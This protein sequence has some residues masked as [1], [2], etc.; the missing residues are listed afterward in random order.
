MFQFQAFYTV[1]IQFAHK[2][3]QADRK[4]AIL[5]LGQMKKW[6]WAKS[7]ELL[8]LYLSI[9]LSQYVYLQQGI[10]ALKCG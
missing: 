5:I 2:V 4:F 10:F 3:T 9:K 8:T 6:L 7:S 1:G